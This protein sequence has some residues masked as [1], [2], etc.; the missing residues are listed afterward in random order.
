MNYVLLAGLLDY[1]PLTG[2]LTWNTRPGARVRVGDRAGCSGPEGYRV[3][4]WKG[5]RYLEQRIIILKMTGTLPDKADHANLNKGDNRWVN[6]R[7]ANSTQNGANRARQKNNTTGF[8]GVSKASPNTFKASIRLGGKNPVHLGSFPT[9]E[10]AG[11]AY[12]EKADAVI[13]ACR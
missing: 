7:P 10:K 2:W 1:D 3:V 12:A 8:K 5:H 4:K 6:L 11:K 13:Q 9:A